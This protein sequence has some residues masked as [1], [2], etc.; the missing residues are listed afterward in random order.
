MEDKNTVKAYHFDDNNGNIRVCFKEYY[1]RIPETMRTEHIQ[2]GDVVLVRSKQ[3]SA[4]V[5]V[6]DV[7]QEADEITEK[8]KPVIKKLNK[9]I[10]IDIDKLKAAH[11]A[12]RTLM[13]QKRAEKAAKKAANKLKAEESAKI[14]AEKKKAKEAAKNMNKADTKP[15]P[16]DTAD[17]KA[18]ATKINPFEKIKA[19]LYNKINEPQQ[20]SDKIRRQ[21]K[22]DDYINWLT[23]RRQAIENGSL[24][25]S[26][27][28]ED[29]AKLT[30]VRIGKKTE[31]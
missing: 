17:N 27:A 23:P 11:A 9:R 18:N 31:K 20:D 12:N 3:G 24:K 19:H 13:E 25:Y 28:A 21:K 26:D 8:H 30:G 16:A 4:P 2:K 10:E 6:D 15:K 29:I 7:L 5:I 22:Y 1:W 14:A